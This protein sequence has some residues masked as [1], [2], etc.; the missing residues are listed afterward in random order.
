MFVSLCV[1]VCVYVLECA[2]RGCNICA[3]VVSVAC[4]CLNPTAGVGMYAEKGVCGN[5]CVCV[6]MCA[7]MWQCVCLCVRISVKG[8]ADGNS[9][10][11]K[12]V[13]LACVLQMV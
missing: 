12:A 6:A 4:C 9:Y 1:C 3:S 11:R 5:V 13:A 8:Q 2:E 10:K 7:Y